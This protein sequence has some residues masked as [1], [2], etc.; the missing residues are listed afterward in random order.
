[1]GYCF[2]T[3]EKIKNRQQI[4]GKYLHNYRQIDVLN[5]DPDKKHLNQELVS[6]NGKD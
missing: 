2:M 5:A 6:L 4:A 1:M 3:I